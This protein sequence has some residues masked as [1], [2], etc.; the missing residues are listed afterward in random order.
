M[1]PPMRLRGRVAAITG[2]ALG[3]GR[4]RARLFAAEGA[5]VAIGDVAQHHITVN[6]VAPAQIDTRLT[7]GLSESATRRRGLWSS[8]PRA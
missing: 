2:G 3:I 7:R 5:L 1:I 4:A 8:A 6:A